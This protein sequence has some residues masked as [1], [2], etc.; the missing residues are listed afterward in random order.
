[1]YNMSV[2][3]HVLEAKMK[4]WI[5]AVFSLSAIINLIIGTELEK[6]PIPSGLP[7]KVFFLLTAVLC[8]LVAWHGRKQK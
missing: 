4:F 1:M 5:F 8:G 3:K 6:L 2:K 7:T